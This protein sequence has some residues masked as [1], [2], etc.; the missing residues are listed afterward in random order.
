MENQYDFTSRNTLNAS[1]AAEYLFN[2]PGASDADIAANAGPT[3]GYS[4]PKSM[5]VSIK[6]IE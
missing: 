3:E 2:N 5:L 6:A 4:G 1:Y